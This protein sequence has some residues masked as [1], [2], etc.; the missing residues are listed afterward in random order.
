MK[1]ELDYLMSQTLHGVN[2]DEKELCG[3]DCCQIQSANNCLVGPP[4]L[5]LGWQQCLNSHP[6]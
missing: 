1:L 6:W 5:A 3:D 2:D 4:H